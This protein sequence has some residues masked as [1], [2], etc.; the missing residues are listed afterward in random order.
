MQPKVRRAFGLLKETAPFF[1]EVV[2]AALL[3][4]RLLGTI[5]LVG[6]ES[7]SRLD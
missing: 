4:A 7:G 5:A 3:D 6:P 2:R 1:T